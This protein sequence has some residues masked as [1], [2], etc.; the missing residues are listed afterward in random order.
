[1]YCPKCGKEISSKAK[2]CPMCGLNIKDFFNEKSEEAN[3]EENN[4]IKKE[5]I[6]GKSKEKEKNRLEDLFIE[7]LEDDTDEEFYEGIEENSKRDYK[8]NVKEIK[9]NL[10]DILE[11][12]KDKSRILLNIIKRSQEYI[13]SKG[14]SKVNEI[15]FGN[16]NYIYFLLGIIII[17]L[18]IPTFSAM[19]IFL[20]FA[21]ST[22][23]IYLLLF[24]LLTVFVNMLI[25]ASGPFI[26]FKILGL[27][28][29]EKIDKAT[30]KAF[31]IITTS[32]ISIY[33]LLIFLLTKNII[34]LGTII[35][36]KFSFGIIAF[37]I[38]MFLL[39]TYFMT[40][41]VWDK[42]D[43]K[44]YIKVFITIFLTLAIVEILSYLVFKP[45]LFIL[46]DI[47]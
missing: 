46:L 26:S 22:N 30:I 21:R 19:K 4:E 31:T 44:N 33:K 12:I 42:F 10:G 8:E 1:M 36:G 37:N 9:N 40:I 16:K 35:L 43:K 28:Y 29:M 38:I 5:K 39:A 7:D 18:V 25:T 15:I 41:L 45:T 6:D 47:I 27:N 13:F 2:F 24:T 20:L 14:Q 3:I 11:I 17:S 34:T 23:K 32:I